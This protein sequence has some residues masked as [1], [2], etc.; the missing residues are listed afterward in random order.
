L[1]LSVA[2]DGLLKEAF[3]RLAMPSA[4]DR[5]NIS[6]AQDIIRNSSIDSKVKARLNG[7][8]GTMSNP[9]A[10][11]RLRVFLETGILDNKLTDSWESLRNPSTHGD[12][13]D[14]RDLQRYIDKCSST[15][16]LFYQL[17][18]LVIEYTGKFTNY[19]CEG[20][21]TVLFDKRLT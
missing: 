11:D 6:E 3:P 16:V 1:T 17:I 8:I 5:R 20:Y 10:K 21:P 15:L 13:A 9:R 12:V 14:W 4:A 19:S 2:V 7:F 18:F